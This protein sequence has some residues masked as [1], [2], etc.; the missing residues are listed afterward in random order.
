VRRLERTQSTER[1]ERWGKGK[2]I[3]D[4]SRSTLRGASTSSVLEGQGCARKEET[5]TIELVN[6]GFVPEEI[7][8]S[9][10]RKPRRGD[11]ANGK[12]P[13]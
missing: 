11:P 13:G 6:S 7:S 5:P 3:L 9:K 4:S 10:K 2:E 1:T 8:G 12:V